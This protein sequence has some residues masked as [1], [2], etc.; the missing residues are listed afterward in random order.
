[1]N[2]GDD[3][4]RGRRRDM[5]AEE[6]R[7][8]G[9]RYGPGAE[10]LRELRACILAADHHGDVGTVEREGAGDDETN[11]V[12]HTGRAKRPRLAL[13]RFAMPSKQLAVGAGRYAEVL[14]SREEGLAVEG[15]SD[16]GLGHVHSVPRQ[17]V[18]QRRIPLGPDRGRAPERVSGAMHHHYSCHRRQC[19][20][21]WS[22]A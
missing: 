12:A 10:H 1:M 14:A 5:R 17:T 22:Q 13:D 8:I 4:E 9:E 15:D 2:V 21:A 16:V 19:A 3:D 6:P 20:T 18:G 11:H 7:H